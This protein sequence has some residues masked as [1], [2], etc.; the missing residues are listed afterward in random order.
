MPIATE[1]SCFARAASIGPALPRGSFRAEVMGIHRAAINIG[2][3]GTGFVASIVGPS[4]RGEPIAIV[5]PS[6]PDF[7]SWPLEIG[8]MGYLDAGNLKLGGTESAFAVAIDLRESTRIE[9]IPMPTISSLGESWTLAVS[10]LVRIQSMKSTELR[11]NALL[12]GEGAS[13]FPLSAL[14]RAI[15]AL[16]RSP[17][18]PSLEIIYKIVGSGQGLTPAGDD[19]LV[20]YAGAASSIAGQLNMG[21]LP[22]PP[23]VIAAA[24]VEAADSTT[25]LSASML[26]LAAKGHYPAHLGELAAALAIKDS[27]RSTA[28]LRHVCAIGHSSGADT[29]T[30]F[31]YGLGLFCGF[32][33]DDRAM[34]PDFDKARRRLYAS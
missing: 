22:F 10:E 21:G 30:G 20:G 15:L 34:S 25:A 16:S 3:V 14:T 32:G 19:F 24:L 18:E 1:S 2:L 9:P 23:Q 8:A 29:A 31:L 4:H 28:A 33:A 26:R 5:L 11:M 7:L 27:A 13:I 17:L 12:G 6:Q